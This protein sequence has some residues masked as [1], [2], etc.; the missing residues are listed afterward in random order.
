MKRNISQRKTYHITEEEL[1]NKMVNLT[2]PDG[3]KELKKLNPLQDIDLTA[4]EIGLAKNGNYESAQFEGGTLYD[5]VCLLFGSDTLPDGRKCTELKFPLDIPKDDVIGI[6]KG[7]GAHARLNNPWAKEK[8]IAGYDIL[9]G[10]AYM[11]N[12]YDEKTDN[13]IL[14]NPHGD[15]RRSVDDDIIMPIDEFRMYFS[16]DYFTKADS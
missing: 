13:V 16:I 2:M 15:D 9:G 6:L 10:H 11:V 4:L 14:S 3:S 12:D 5:T 8:Q 1:K 7:G